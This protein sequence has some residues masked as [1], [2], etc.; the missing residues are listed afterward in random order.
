MLVERI[1]EVC[2]KRLAAGTSEKS[3]GP[4]GVGTILKTRYNGAFNSMRGLRLI[5]WLLVLVWMSLIFVGST[6]LLASRHTSRFLFPLLRWLKPDISQATMDEVQRFVRK[7]GHVS[8]Y[9]VL[10]ILVI[11]ALKTPRN[12]QPNWRLALAICALY[13][14]S[15]EF[16]Q[17]F[18][19]TRDGTVH[20]VLID[21]A[22]AS[23]GLG[24]FALWVN[25]RRPGP[26]IAGLAGT[27]EGAG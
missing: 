25:R 7:S 11:C 23:V 14:A 1:A 2:H 21:T 16:H 5:R 17:T 8:E 19:P 12:P 18:V 22:G 13:A 9:G 24:V 20:D 10:A 15:D 4:I 27:P 3:Q 6:D 26:P